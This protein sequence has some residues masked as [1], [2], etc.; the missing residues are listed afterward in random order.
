MNVPAHNVGYNFWWVPAVSDGPAVQWWSLKTR[1]WKQGVNTRP[2]PRSGLRW[3]H[4]SAQANNSPVLGQSGQNQGRSAPRGE[5]T[6]HKINERLTVTFSTLIW[7]THSL[8]RPVDT[9]FQAISE[10]CWHECTN[11]QRQLHGSNT[12]LCSHMMDINHQKKSHFYNS[13]QF[14][15]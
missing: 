6:S 4:N 15:Y 1:Q 12:S 8:E 5:T 10:T 9:S 7:N 14:G 3:K 2:N 13:Q 11:I